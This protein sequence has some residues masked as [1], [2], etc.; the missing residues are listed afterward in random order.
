MTEAPTPAFSR[1]ALDRVR[2]ATPDEWDATFAACPWATFFHSRTWA[3]IWAEYTRGQIRPSPWLAEFSDGI[4]AILPISLRSSRYHLSSTALLSPGGTYGGPISSDPLSAVHLRLLV[5]FMRRHW[6]NIQYRDNPYLAPSIPPFG[7]V[8]PGTTQRIELARIQHTST[9]LQ[10]KGHASAV[11]K[12]RKHGILIARATNPNDWASYVQMYEASITRW[13]TTATSHYTPAL[14]EILR[15]RAETTSDISLWLARYQGIPVAGAVIFS[16]PH[17]A[18]YWH[19][20]ALDEYFDMRPVNL[21][22]TEAIDNAREEGKQWFDFNPSGGHA[23]VIRF[24]DG[25]GPTCA[26]SDH[27]DLRTPYL[28]NFVRRIHSALLSGLGGS[29]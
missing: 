15:R 13:G 18:I 24:K 25:F 1:I 26:H 7:M 5:Q 10:R 6:K 21:L 27:Y 17:I 2:L 29:Q 12:A 9:E 11:T 16:T 20:A 22:L 23:G 28:P 19:G 4:R 3:E 8:N 14:F